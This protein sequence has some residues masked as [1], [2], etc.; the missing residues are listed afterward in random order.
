M[1]WLE[2]HNYT[3][4][5]FQIFCG[6]GNNGGDGLAIARMLAERKCMVAVHILEFGNKGTD[7]FQQNLARLHQYP[8]ITIRFIQTEDNFHGLHTNDI[9]IDAALPGWFENR[10]CLYDQ[11]QEYKQQQN[12]FFQPTCV[13]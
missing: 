6:K 9:I 12:I 7:D 4:K 1:E 3:D 2:R 8:A 10:L 11:I 13:L 5:S